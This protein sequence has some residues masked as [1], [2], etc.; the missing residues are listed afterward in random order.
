MGDRANVYVHQG[1][2]PGVY[3]Y[4]HWRGTELPDIVRRALAHGERWSDDQYL[5]RIILDEMTGARD[6]AFAGY[7]ISAYIGDGGSRI[8]DVDTVLQ[9]VT[10]V[11]SGD[12]SEAWPF[13]AYVKLQEVSWTS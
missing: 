4:T 6:D 11:L 9:V 12:L 8:V 2:T 5:A 1:T 13:R 3:L 10:L 7:G